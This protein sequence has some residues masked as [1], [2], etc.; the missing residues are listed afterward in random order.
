MKRRILCPGLVARTCLELRLGSRSALSQSI[1]TA[2]S[3]SPSSVV[4]WRT[5]VR[6]RREWFQLHHTLLRAQERHKVPDNVRHLDSPEGRHSSLRHR[7]S[8][9]T[10]VA[11]A[12]NW[13]N[14]LLLVS[15]A[16]SLARRPWRSQMP[17]S[18]LPRCLSLAMLLSY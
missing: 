15:N 16:L 7:R 9:R 6:I 4:G 18:N 13:V 2:A 3:I 5:W 17:S 8:R 1:P 10:Q 11:V 14:A 12:T